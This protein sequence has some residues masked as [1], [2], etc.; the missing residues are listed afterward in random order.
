[1]P[2]EARGMLTVLLEYI[3]TALLEYIQKVT[4]LLE[5]IDLFCDMQYCILEDSSF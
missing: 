4:V 1:M 2:D 3:Q 5:Y